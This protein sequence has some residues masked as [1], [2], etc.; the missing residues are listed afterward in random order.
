L[1]R[2]R[3][4]VVGS[5]PLLLLY[6]IDAHSSPQS[7]NAREGL[8]AVSHLLGFGIVFPG[9]LDTSGRFYSVE[10]DPLSA[11]EIEEEDIGT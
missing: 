6:G 8:Q 4:T 1:K 9:S 2:A 10:L 3:E 11:D 7:G 5:V